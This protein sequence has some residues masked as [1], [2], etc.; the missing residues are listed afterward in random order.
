MR[1]LDKQWGM[2]LAILALAVP[3]A[4]LSGCGKSDSSPAASAAP[5]RPAG[6][7]AMEKLYALAQKEGTVVYWTP[8]ETELETRIA[9]EFAKTYPGIKVVPFSIKPGNAVERITS[10]ASA[11]RASVDLLSSSL[12]SSVPLLDRGLVA[13]FDGF[14]EMPAEVRHSLLLDGRFLNSYNLDYVLSYNTN[15][16]S[17]DL[18]PKTWGDLLDPRLR[19]KIG[20]EMRAMP[21]GYLGVAWGEARLVEYLDKLLKQKPFFVKGGN[22][23]ADQVASGESPIAIGT[24]SYQVE[25]LK[26]AG[27]P[28]GYKIPE[29]VGISNFGNLLVKGA[30]HPNAAKLYAAWTSS[31]E[32]Q[33]VIHKLL[34]RGSLMPDSHLPQAEK[35]RDS[36]AALVFDDLENAKLRKRM[37][38][39]AAKKLGVN[40]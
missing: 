19:G 2:G 15:M 32:G 3:L 9:A 14:D 11:G 21:F 40:R 31:K 34:G 26:G 6:N 33:T 23:I 7:G 8:T 38:D 5:A 25:L 39:L 4:C 35:I 30:Q 16:I 24:Y 12:A 27:A 18:A 17:E 28:V 29:T 36:R 13:A 22:T 10:E 20:I 37:E 1:Y